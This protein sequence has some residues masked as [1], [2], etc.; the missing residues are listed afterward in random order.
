MKSIVYKGKRITRTVVRNNILRVWHQASASEQSFD[1]YQ[2]A[3]NECSIIHDQTGCGLRKAVGVMAALSPR[4]SWE[5]NMRIA[6][7]FVETGD[8]GQIQLFKTKAANIMALED[9]TDEDIME[10]LG[11]RKIQAFYMNIMYPHQANYVTID[12][13]A[14]SVAFNKWVSDDFYSGMTANQYEF[15]LQCYVLA[16]TQVGTTPLVM[17]SAT[18]TTWRKIKR[19]FDRI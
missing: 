16:A 18:W 17:Q 4:K 3:L 9:P 14:L 8:C 6:K 15:F 19:N 12:R 7:E 10:V 11:G 1:W 2:A 5:I 13:H